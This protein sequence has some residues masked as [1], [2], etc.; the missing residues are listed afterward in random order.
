M[1]SEPQNSSMLFRK[2]HLHNKIFIFFNFGHFDFW[3]FLGLMGKFGQKLKCPKLKNMKIVLCKWTLGNNI[4]E[5]WG[6]EAIISGT[7]L[8]EYRRI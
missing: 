8:L 2:V 4:L 6:S 7:L 5:F 1:A 3:A